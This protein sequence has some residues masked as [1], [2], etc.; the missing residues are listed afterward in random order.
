MH[1]R[2]RLAAQVIIGLQQNLKKSREVL[3]A[4]ER[5]SFR[6]RRTLVCGCRN[7][8]RIRSAHLGNQQI[9]Y[10]PNRFTAEMLQVAPFLLKRVDQPQRPV[11]RALRNRAYQRGREPRL[12]APVLQ[13]R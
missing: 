2:I 11:G 8:I 4:K 7:Q 3:F 1:S 9:P 5:R 10:V 6:Q 13:H 12:G